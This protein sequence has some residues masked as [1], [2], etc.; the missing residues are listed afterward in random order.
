MLSDQTLARLLAFRE[1]RDWAQFHSFRNLAVSLSIESAELLE[2][3]QWVSDADVADV[4]RDRRAEI[5]GEIADIASY[6]A[7]LAHDLGVDVDQCV[8]QKLEVNEKRYPVEKAK[9]VATK[10]DRLK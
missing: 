3:V 10:Y 6:L 7:L 5:C 2:L 8:R 9:G 1:E 4:V